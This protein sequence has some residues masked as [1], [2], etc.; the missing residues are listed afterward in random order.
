MSQLLDAIRKAIDAHSARGVTRYRIAQ[1]SGVSEAQLS[2]LMSG[3]SG[4]SVEVAEHLAKHLNL[5]IIVRSARA[6]QR[7]SK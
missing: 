2:R 1:D 6:A 7:K 3:K 5:E 4:L